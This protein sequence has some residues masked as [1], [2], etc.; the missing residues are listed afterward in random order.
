[1]LTV[2]PRETEWIKM[3]LKSERLKKEGSQRASP[4]DEQRASFQLSSAHLKEHWGKKGCNDCPRNMFY[5]FHLT[6]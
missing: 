4:T 6:Y 2:L 1:M 3:T 5:Y